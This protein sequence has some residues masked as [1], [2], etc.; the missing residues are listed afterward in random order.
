ME[1]Q[2]QRHGCLTAWLVLMILIN[3]VISLVFI[4]RGDEISQT[5]PGADQLTVIILT[6]LS[7]FNVVCAVAIAKWK[8]WGF[9][10]V[11]ATL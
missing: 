8:R 5:T 1:E 7:A 11:I 10:T 6:F 3:S 4:F 9:W 2:K